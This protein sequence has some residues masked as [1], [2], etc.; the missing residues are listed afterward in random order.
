[1]SIVLTGVVVLQWVVVRS[2]FSSS[3]KEPWMA[4]QINARPAPVVV[5]H[6]Q[7]RPTPG[8]FRLLS[9][10][11]QFDNRLPIYGH[12]SC[13]VCNTV[14]ALAFSLVNWMTWNFIS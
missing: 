14:L 11:W 13:T 7:A 8:L 9:L 4:R 5:E 6:F 10:F 3:T 12:N 2:S 1:M